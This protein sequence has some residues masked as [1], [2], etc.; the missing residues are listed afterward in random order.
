VLQGELVH[1]PGGPRRGHEL[2]EHVNQAGVVEAVDCVIDLSRE[3][4]G[5]SHRA[6]ELALGP[7][8]VFATEE[9]HQH[10]PFDVA[11]RLKALALA[12]FCMHGKGDSFPCHGPG[13]VTAVAGAN[14]SIGVY[15]TV[16]R[17]AGGRSRKSG[18]AGATAMVG[19][20][21]A[22]VRE[23]S[24]I[25]LYEKKMSAIALKI[26]S[27]RL[28]VDGSGSRAVLRATQRPSLLRR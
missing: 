14:S 23:G 19:L 3:P 27:L 15:L 10:R 24:F 2:A 13:A 17:R 20:A 28:G 9:L 21:D 7:H 16:Y 25:R 18:E 8:A 22:G 5:A 6:F 1:L 12:T 4:A 11:R 26:R